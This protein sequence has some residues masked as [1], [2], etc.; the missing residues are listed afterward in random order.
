MESHD[1]VTK[2]PSF[3]QRQE[4]TQNKNDCSETFLYKTLVLATRAFLATLVCRVKAPLLL[5]HFISFTCELINYLLQKN[6]KKGFE[7]VFSPNDRENLKSGLR[8]VKFIALI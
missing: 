6:K 7:T 4:T 1:A 2:I 5:S 8:G 3:Q